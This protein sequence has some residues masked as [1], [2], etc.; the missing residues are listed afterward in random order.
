MYRYTCTYPTLYVCVHDPFML[1][2]FLQLGPFFHEVL[3]EKW[4]SGSLTA[5]I[6][7]F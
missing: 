6:E 2:L 3:S 1:T 7:H 4:S 5:W